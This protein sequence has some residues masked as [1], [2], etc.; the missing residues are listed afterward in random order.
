VLP[1]LV[2][3][4]THWPLSDRSGFAVAEDYGRNVLESVG[5]N[6]IL[7]VSG[8]Q[9]TSSVF[10]WLQKVEGVRTDV[11]VID[12]RETYHPWYMNHFKVLHPGVRLNKVRTADAD[13]KQS[14][15]EGRV[16]HDNPVID[17]LILENIPRPGVQGRR[18]YMDPWRL[19][20][21]SGTFFIPGLACRILP[22]GRREEYDLEG[23]LEEFSAGRFDGFQTDESETGKPIPRIADLY[24]TICRQL[25]EEFNTRGEPSTAVKIVQGGINRFPAALRIE[26]A[27]MALASYLRSMGRTDEAIRQLNTALE[28]A[29]E[30][31]RLVK[32]KLLIRLAELMNDNGDDNATREL[33]A[34]AGALLK[35]AER[36]ARE[37]H[38]P[39]DL[40]D[41][42]EYQIL[43]LQI[44]GELNPGGDPEA[45]S[46][47]RRIDEM[48]V[49]QKE[50]LRMIVPVRVL[51]PD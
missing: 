33:L 44:E 16:Y 50:L 29:D 23:H 22:A 49:R 4:F 10:T 19:G 41:A 47:R 9:A 51:P 20:L 15:K 5:Q 6:G 42:L 7:I 27:R 3:A 31:E 30:K 46:R 40:Y 12:I 14:L 48:R 18:V 45:Q 32:G 43:L 11:D 13:P 1:V 35:D 2:I 39:G 24:L 37:S 25:A 34:R 36:E 8:E 26:Y 21:R 28:G 17:D 38:R